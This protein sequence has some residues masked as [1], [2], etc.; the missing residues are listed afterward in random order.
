[1]ELE[2]AVGTKE[3]IQEINTDSLNMY[4][5]HL[6]KEGYRPK[7]ETGNK[8][9]KYIVFKCEGRHFILDLPYEDLFKICIPWIWEINLNNQEEVEHIHK[10]LFKVNNNMRVSKIVVVGEE[11]Y[12]EAEAFIS[13]HKN[14]IEVLQQY[15]D[16]V[17]Y[18]TREFH[19]EMSSL[20]QAAWSSPDTTSATWN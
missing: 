1:M 2:N 13:E 10:A 5:E 16:N 6:L 7:L 20:D 4:F 11:V 14:I 8:G 9:N 17:L 19:D 3:C 15:I 18:A 12:A